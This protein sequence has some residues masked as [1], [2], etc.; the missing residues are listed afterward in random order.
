MSR[1]EP[2]QQ[3]THG[4][5]REDFVPMPSSPLKREA[6]LPSSEQ[7]GPPSLVGELHLWRQHL[8]QRVQE[9]AG[10]SP[11][12]PHPGTLLGVPVLGTRLWYSSAAPVSETT[13]QC[14]SWY[15]SA[16]SP[17]C[18]TSQRYKSAVLVCNSTLQNPSMVCATS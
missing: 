13:L 8:H 16:G 9:A 18:G 1:Y 12:R 17:T 11:K 15:Q 6:H 14:L 2:S 4:F 3:G 5:I 10:S 7:V